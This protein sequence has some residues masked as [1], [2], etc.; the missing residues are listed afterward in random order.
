MRD[1]CVRPLQ[2]VGVAVQQGFDRLVQVRVVLAAGVVLQLPRRQA[3]REG[4]VGELS[5]VEEVAAVVDVQALTQVL[6][7][8]L[9]VHAAV[10]CC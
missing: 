8:E 3:V 10:G 2:K 1:T 6:Q 5:R 9:V 4:V 7:R